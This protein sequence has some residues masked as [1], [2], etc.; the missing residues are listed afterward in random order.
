MLAPPNP[1]PTRS[2]PALSPCARTPLLLP[3]FRTFPYHCPFCSLCRSVG[4][5][6]AHAPAQSVSGSKKPTPLPPPQV[7]VLSLL[8]NTLLEG[9]VY[10]RYHHIFNPTCSSAHST[11]SSALAPALVSPPQARQGPLT[12]TTCF[13]VLSSP[14][15]P[16]APDKAYTSCLL[17]VPSPPIPEHHSPAVPTTGRGTRCS[18]LYEELRGLGGRAGDRERSGGATRCAEYLQVSRTGSMVRTGMGRQSHAPPGGP[19]G[20]IHLLAFPSV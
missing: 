11:L 18:S 19:R 6:W 2:H 13:S 15:S 10:T 8:Y 4:F 7:N 14:R 5:A 12:P 3:P 9:S 1:L 20:R 16:V 17:K